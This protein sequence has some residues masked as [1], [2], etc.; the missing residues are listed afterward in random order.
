M[1]DYSFKTTP[2]GHQL[3]LFRETRN[4]Y[5]YCIHWEMGCGKSKPIIDTAA[6]LYLDG[7]IN[8]VVI[9]APNGVH[10]NWRDNELPAHLPDAVAAQSHVHVWDAK[11]AKTKAAQDNF[12]K[13]LRHPGLAWLMIGYGAL[14]T[15]RCL[16]AAE[17][18]LETRRCL[19]ALD[20]S[21]RIKNPSSARTKALLRLRTFA[22]YRRT[23]TGTP[24]TQNAFD[25]YA[26]VLFAYP[27]YWKSQGFGSWTAF[28]G[29][30]GT[31]E[32]VTDH[33]R[34]YETGRN[35]KKKG[36]TYEKL[37]RHE[38]L[39]ELNRLMQPIS[40]RLTKDEAL[41][42]PPKVYRTISYDM[43]PEQRR[44]FKEL[45]KDY[46]TWIDSDKAVTAEMA[47]Q[48]LLRMQQLVNGYVLA[49]GED[50]VTDLK[51]NPRLDLLRD[52]LEDADGATL[53]W[54]RFRRDV[55]K[56]MDLLGNMGRRAARIDGGVCQSDRV[57][58][59]KMLQAGELDNLVM[60]AAAAGEGWTMTAAKHSIYFSNSY[61]LTDRLQSEDRNHRIGQTTSVLYTDII[62]RGSMDAA[63]L[64]ALRSKKNISDIILG[65]ER[66]TWFREQIS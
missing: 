50:E 58:A 48:K 2:F 57:R 13:T 5:G 64:R 24:V 32:L 38:N 31:W 53:I 42:L 9:V 36:R 43:S 55:D 21:A 7:K 34:D 49:D 66:K 46:V 61:R 8:A 11:T 41:D 10:S 4:Q 63:V 60:T 18:F 45:E 3:T 33:G 6:W 44:M 14:A 15:D 29:Y 65:D 39:D 51:D 52:M 28:K 59:V 62:A 37:I 25:V 40:S 30:F 54:A 56:I 16:E 23:L 47:I 19:F 20:E 12:T 22:P 26:Q 35:E 1:D 17:E 27:G